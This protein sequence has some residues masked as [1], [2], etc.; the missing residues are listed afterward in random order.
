MRVGSYKDKQLYNLSLLRML[1]VT[2]AL[3][4]HC[5]VY[6]QILLSGISKVRDLVRRNLGTLLLLRQTLK[7][8]YCLLSFLITLPTTCATHFQGIQSSTFRIGQV[9]DLLLP[10]QESI[11]LSNNLTSCLSVFQLAKQY[12]FCSTFS[13]TVRFL[14]L[15][16]FFAIIIQ[17]IGQQEDLLI[18][19]YLLKFF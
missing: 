9:C 15:S 16:N 17:G 6:S 2:E 19:L 11:F 5:V 8:S 12:Y 3:G 1:C 14:P 4:S 18:I 7:H 13:V 10:V